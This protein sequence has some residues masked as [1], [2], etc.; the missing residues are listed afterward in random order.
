MTVKEKSRA[1]S[2]L[3]GSVMCCLGGTGIPQVWAQD[4]LDIEEADLLD[5]IYV[6]FDRRDEAVKDQPRAVTVIKGDDLPKGE[7]EYGPAIANRTPGVTFSGFGQPGT[8]FLNVRGVGALGYPLSATDQLVGI[9][10]DEV[11]TTMF[12]FPPSLFDM[13]QIE[14]ARGPQGTLFGRNALA[15]GINF[16]PNRAD[17]ERIGYIET[18]LGSDGYKT[19]DAVLGDWLIP[20]RLAGRLALHFQDYDG[21]ISNTNA[22][23]ELGGSREAGARLSLSA[24]TD[25]GWDI[26]V[27]GQADYQ[28]R[29]NSFQIYY[30]HPDYPVSGENRVPE[31]TRDNRQVS[32]R[33]EKEFGNVAFTSLSGWQQQKLVNSPGGYDI[34]L[35]GAFT[36]LP[37]SF[38]VEDDPSYFRDIDEDETIFS[39]EFRLASVEDTPL[40]W[41]AG[42]NYMNS[43]YTGHRDARDNFNTTSNG[44]TDVDIDTEA[45]S[46]FGDATL[47]VGDRLRLSGGI[48]YGYEKQSVDGRYVSNGFPGTVPTFNQKDSIGDHYATGRLGLSYDLTDALTGYLSASRGYAAGGYEKLLIGAANGTPTV[49]FEAATNDAFEAGLKFRSLDNRFTANVATFYNR[50]KNGQMFDYTFSGPSVVYYFTNQDYNTWGIELEGAA[51][52]VDNFFVRGSVTL[53]D[54]ELVNV[55]PSTL[56]G[57]KNGNQVPLAPNVSTNLGV[58]YRLSGDLLGMEGDI[59]L[60]AEWTYVG[61]RQADPANSW[62]IPSYN[63]FNTRLA[64]EHDSASMY[65]FANNITDERPIYFASTY[66]PDVHAV[67]IGQ[68]R[69]LGA[70]LSL[71]F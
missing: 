49:P 55:S 5:T 8:D 18:S 69:V 52:V 31:N 53:Q 51:E 62:D 6:H 67:S 19:A 41:V 65:L 45:W 70:G 28:R 60:G 43:S 59:V 30:E 26:S 7:I 54:S 44:V 21:S 3:L 61:E 10:V 37:S 17:G 2:F 13:E 1:R 38:F 39:H 23:G 56:T 58:D 16:V 27:V 22:G 66:S 24:Y 9:T 14:F 40:S 57:A 68:G 64:W 20:D 42:I 4:A 63:L 34:Y 35:F 47:P 25:N 32:L 33:V 12:G 71:K 11:P 48:R 50:V 29:N 36:G 46:V 15:G